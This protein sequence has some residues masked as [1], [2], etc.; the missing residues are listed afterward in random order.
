MLK[1]NF[2]ILNTL[3]FKSIKPINNSIYLQSLTY[4]PF[5]KETYKKGYNISQLRPE[6]KTLKRQMKY[7]CIP[8]WLKS[9][10]KDEF[11]YPLRS[12]EDIAFDQYSTGHSFKMEAEI[13]TYYENADTKMEAKYNMKNEVVCIE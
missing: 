1:L 4:K 9:N 7:P 12:R 10:E 3:K 13:R 8:Q 2:N 6:R 11:N 5:S